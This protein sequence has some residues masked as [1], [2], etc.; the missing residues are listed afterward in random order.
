MNGK[1]GQGEEDALAE[2]GDAEDV[3]E[4]I[5]HRIGSS[6]TVKLQLCCPITSGADWVELPQSR[7]R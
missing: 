1:H 3:G 7:H 6:E 4:F 2:I 5:E